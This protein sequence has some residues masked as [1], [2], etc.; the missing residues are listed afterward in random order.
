MHRHNIKICAA[1]HFNTNAYE[2][3]VKR[4]L[5]QVVC[6]TGGFQIQITTPGR[7]WKT[8]ALTE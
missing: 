2:K 3:V 7:A 1:V 8:K 5:N 6:E 4:T